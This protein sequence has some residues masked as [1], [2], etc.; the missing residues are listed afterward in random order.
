MKKGQKRKSE[1][2]ETIDQI[3]Y[4]SYILYLLAMVIT[5]EI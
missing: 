1:G 2:H 4:M 5:L 3:I